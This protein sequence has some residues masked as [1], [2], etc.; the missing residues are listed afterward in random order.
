MQLLPRRGSPRRKAWITR[1][2]MAAAALVVIAWVALPSA[3]R[4]YREWKKERA[5]AQAEEFLAEQDFP[6]A[7][8]A[9]DVA[10]AAK[11]G[12]PQTLRVA[13]NL[14]EQ[15]GAPEVMPLRRR[16]VQV[17]PESTEDHAA[18]VL[19]ALR[20]N[21]LNAARDAMRGMTPEQANEP[22]AL[23][24]AL[25]YA[26]ATNNLP[27]ADL[28]YARLRE[29]EPENDNLH[30]LHATLRL[31][32]PTPS[33]RAE[34]LAEL[35]AFK[36]EPRHSL[37]VMRQLLVDAMARQDMDRA[38]Q[39]A[40]E[41]R[42]D[43][44]ATLDDHLHS[45]NLALNVEDRPFEDVFAE[46]LPVVEATPENTAILLRWLILVGEANRARSWLV[47]QDDELKSAP[48]VLE[49]RADLAIA[50]SAWDRLADL[51]ESGV[52]GPV[53][54]DTV[55]LAFSARLAAQ[56]DNAALQDQI[57]NEALVSAS[58]SLPD[59]TLL[60][61]LASIW[62][63]EDQAE[64]PLWV[65]AENFPSRTWAHQTLY[66]VYRLRR[67]TENMKALIGTLRLSD[68]TL[69]RYQYDW[70]LLS[71]LL[72]ERTIWTEEKQTMQTLYE[73]DPD[74]AYYITG[75]AFALAQSD[76]EDEAVEI[77]DRINEL[78][79]NLPERAPYLAFVY[80][81]AMKPGA[82]DTFVANA[83]GF[84][85]LLPEETQLLQDARNMVR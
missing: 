36:A 15:V 49:A 22:P 59:L 76:R 64:A 4:A 31:N 26:Q 9:L 55:R 28:L 73:S 44:R 70:A 41:L 3:T 2:I 46:I 34:A 50:Q 10:L 5:L 42:K 54:R 82:V 25:A 67:D 18:L 11:P 80:A 30:V 60:Y 78:E 62:T 58:N 8:L 45:A 1:Y 39:L 19:S 53:D 40:A 6:N 35:D 43:P 74:N 79:R 63:W 23:R 81:A 52:W 68:A 16:L 66:N 48:S 12:D 72:S 65:I 56:R 20:F 14:L 24:A 47:Q 33:V 38:K 71:M 83:E 84:E 57:W 85:N 75:Y 69:P 77:A 51:L 29:L 17:A 7:K 21:D 32:N 37:F 13:A 61:R 27:M